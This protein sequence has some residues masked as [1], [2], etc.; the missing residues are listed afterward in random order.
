MTFTG[1]NFDVVQSPMITITDTRFNIATEVSFLSTWC[2]HNTHS[3]SFNFIFLQS[4][5]VEN[6]DTNLLIC[7]A[8]QITPIN[9]AIDTAIQYK[10]VVDGATGPDSSI[11][12]FELVLKRD[13]TFSMVIDRELQENDIIRIQV[14]ILTII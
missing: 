3:P 9:D 2:T 11:Q 7:T 14:S 5:L 13:P 1:S 10:V 6:N 12:T 4:C 8:P